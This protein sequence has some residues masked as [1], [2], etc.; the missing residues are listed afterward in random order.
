MKPKIK[1]IYNPKAGQKKQKVSLGEAASLSNIV[2]LF[3]RYELPIDVYSS[4]SE[5]DAI[6][7]ARVSKKEGY[8]IVA[9]AGG[10][11]TIATIAH[12][13]VGSNVALAIVPLGTVMNIARMLSIPTN[14]ESA[15]ALIKIGKRHKIDLGQITVLNG[16]NL[17]VPTYFLEQA[18]VGLDAEYRKELHAILEK[19]NL[20]ALPGLIKPI[21][22]LLGH[23]IR[24]EIDGK[25]LKEK[26]RMVTISNGPLSGIALPFA[27]DAM[28]D[29]RHLT[30]TLYT[31]TRVGMIK[32]ALRLFLHMKEKTA[33]VKTYK[34]HTVFIQ[35]D[36]PKVV[37]ADSRVFGMTPAEFR[38]VPAAIVAITGFP[39]AQ[40]SAIKARGISS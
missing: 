24:V 34:A 32:F 21:F 6:K 27:P 7:A 15:V 25:V 10:D 1:L 9:A 16:K 19:G 18:G 14:L 36:E 17:E 23:R 39:E 28:L 31:L 12:G 3:D 33:H 30:V 35:N 37:H 13:L 2:K 5:E 20:M 29:D 38:I 11:G 4:K 8:E 26:A 22:P 40:K